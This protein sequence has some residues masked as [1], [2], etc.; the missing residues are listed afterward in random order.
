[1]CLALFS[2]LNQSAVQYG[3][4]KSYNGI[5]PGRKGQAVDGVAESAGEKAWSA[6]FYTPGQTWFN[7]IQACKLGEW[8][9]LAQLIDAHE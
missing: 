3:N 8:V 6:A 1:M 7:V 4:R 9:S 5:W 2:L